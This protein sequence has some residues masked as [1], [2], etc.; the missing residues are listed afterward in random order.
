MLAVES[1]YGRNEVP[2][3]LIEKGA[4]LNAVD[5]EGNT[6]LMIAIDRNNNEAVELLLA[7]KAAISPRNK[8]GRTALHLASDGLRTKMVALSWQ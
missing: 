1:S 7:H 3:L 8:E 5:L 2:S 6:A 4:D